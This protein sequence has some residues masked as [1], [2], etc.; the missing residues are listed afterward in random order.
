MPRLWCLGGEN[1]GNKT[2]SAFIPLGMQKPG[3][4]IVKI[5]IEFV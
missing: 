1:G 3:I 5:Q 4:D 2:L